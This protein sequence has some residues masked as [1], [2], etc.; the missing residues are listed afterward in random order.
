MH[1]CIE[2]QMRDVHL[3]TVHTF[4]EGAGCTSGS[5]A[6]SPDI[7]GE[8]KSYLIDVTLSTPPSNDSSAP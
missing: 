8:F 6:D 5:P 2:E 4:S 3:S 1:Q 7:S